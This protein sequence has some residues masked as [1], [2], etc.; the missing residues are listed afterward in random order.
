[1]QLYLNERTV[2][3]RYDL[4][5]ELSDKRVPQKSSYKRFQMGISGWMS[6]LLIIASESSKTNCPSSELM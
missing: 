3:G 6:L 2:K 5:L 1:M 4:W